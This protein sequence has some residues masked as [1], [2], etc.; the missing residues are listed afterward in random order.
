[1]KVDING[2]QTAEKEKMSTSVKEAM[3][4]ILSLPTQTFKGA[5]VLQ[6]T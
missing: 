4:K 2:Y 5:V 3:D 6:Q 1:M